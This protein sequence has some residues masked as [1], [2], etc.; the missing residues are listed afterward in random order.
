MRTSPSTSSSVVENKYTKALVA[1][2]CGYEVVAIA[3]RGKIPT[4]TCW[5]TQYKVIAPVILGG[6]AEHFY[7][8]QLR[9]WAHHRLTRAQE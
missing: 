6:L 4:L 2:V 1:S 8:P 5:N 3:S 7:G 9:A